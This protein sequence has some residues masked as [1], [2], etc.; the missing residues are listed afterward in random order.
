[1]KNIAIISVIFCIMASCCPKVLPFESRQSDSIRVE[2]REIL[3]DTAIYVTLPAE[4]VE[5]ERPDTVSYIS[6]S[7][8]ESWA[9]W[10]NGRLYHKLQNKP[11]TP[12]VKI[13]YKDIERDS[14]SFKDRYI[15]EVV[16]VKR[17]P[18]V[19]WWG[20]GV[21]IGALLLIIAWLALKK[22]IL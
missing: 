22:A 12:E 16:T 9:G 13:V 21:V 6:T 8:A 14:T 7:I 20:A 17:V 1:M 19:F 18:G 5:V 2:Y 3:R 4:V 15:K 11:Y 10:S